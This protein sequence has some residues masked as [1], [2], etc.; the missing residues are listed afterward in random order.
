VIGWLHGF[1]GAPAQWD[2][3]R[4]PDDAWW[5]P[6]HGP[7]PRVWAGA[8]FDEVVNALS[9]WT[10]GRRVLVGYSLGARLALALA[11][12]HPGDLRAVVLVGGTPGLAA[13]ADR[14]QRAAADDA[15][16]ATIARDGLAAFVAR[17]EA[18]PLFATQRALPPEALAA[19]RAWRTQHAPEGIAWALSTLSTGRMP[20][21]WDALATAGVAVHAVTG[22]RD[23]KFTRIAEEMVRRGE[24]RVVHHRVAGAG[25]NVVLEDPAAVARVVETAR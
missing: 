10:T 3:L 12:R 6:G 11:L 20:P 19:Q 18:L 2:G 1:L 25:H 5:L 9:P 23:E 8:T 7:S 13:A 21:L 15:L 22:E 4:G 24:G 14:A 16:A 17:W